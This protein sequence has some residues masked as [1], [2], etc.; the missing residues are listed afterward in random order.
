M[1]SWRLTSKHYEIFTVAFFRRN[2]I[3]HQQ[4]TTKAHKIVSNIS[5]LNTKTAICGSHP[6]TERRHVVWVVAPLGGV[7]YSRRFEQTYRHNLQGYK[8]V[9][10]LINLKTSSRGSNAD[11]PFVQ[12]V[13]INT[14]IFQICISLNQGWPTSTNTRVTWFVK[15]LPAGLTLFTYIKKEENELTITLLFTSKKLG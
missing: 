15:D 9:R 1:Y 7:I 2:S 10:G 11:S 8:S 13:P 5:C 14:E 3:M 4:H 12:P 6:V